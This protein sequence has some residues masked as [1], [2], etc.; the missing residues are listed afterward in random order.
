MLCGNIG[1]PLRLEY[2]HIG[3]T[4][5]TASRIEGLTKDLH[6]V[7]L[8]SATTKERAGPGFSFV[9]KGSLHVKGRP[10]PVHVY[11]VD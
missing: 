10:E 7:L 11:G 5:N 2:T 1:S 9:D 8:A 6:T 4:V 3:D